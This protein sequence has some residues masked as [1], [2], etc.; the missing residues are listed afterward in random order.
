M[1]ETDVNAKLAGWGILG[2]PIIRDAVDFV[3]HGISDIGKHLDFKS[4]VKH[5]VPELGGL[6]AMRLTANPIVAGEVTHQ[7]TK[8]IN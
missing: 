6:L 5:V 1:S 3:K 7:L 8:L 4:V 2:L